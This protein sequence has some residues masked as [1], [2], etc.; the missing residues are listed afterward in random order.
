MLSSVSR[1]VALAC[2]LPAAASAQALRPAEPVAHAPG[3]VLRP[4]DAALDTGWIASGTTL[5]AL[6][7]VEPV[8]TEIGTATVD[9]S[10][11]DGG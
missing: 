3:H 10:V 11:A 9:V 5:Y 4:G 8:R 7:I 6:R 1:L 2:L